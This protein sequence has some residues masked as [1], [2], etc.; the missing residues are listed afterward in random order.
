MAKRTAAEIEVQIQKLR[1]DL[2]FAEKNFPKLVPSIKANIARQVSALDVAVQYDLFVKALTS[3]K[4][5]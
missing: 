1:S 5:K 2:A 3:P 4:T